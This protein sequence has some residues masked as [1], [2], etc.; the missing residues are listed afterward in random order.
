[1]VIG[2]SLCKL[3]RYLA[4]VTLWLWCLDGGN[5]APGGFLEVIVCAWWAEFDIL[6][7]VLDHYG[8]PRRQIEQVTGRH[9]LLAIGEGHPHLSC[10]DVS[11]V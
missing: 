11:P 6:D 8:M 7:I 2:P 10:E 5:V 9:R 3:P 1:M 4:T